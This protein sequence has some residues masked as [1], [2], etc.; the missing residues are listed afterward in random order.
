[1][2]NCVN[3]YNLV[4]NDIVCNTPTCKY[5]FCNICY[6]FHIKPCIWCNNIYCTT[7]LCGDNVVCSSCKFKLKRDREK[8]LQE[9][10]QQMEKER[11][12]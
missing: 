10:F 11:K 7:C 12:N 5:M 2:P 4:D 3:C 1:M 9:L 6:P 8:N